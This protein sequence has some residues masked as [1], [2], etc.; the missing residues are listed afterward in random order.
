MRFDGH[1][2]HFG[3]GHFGHSKMRNNILKINQRKLRE[4]INTQLGLK[5]PKVGRPIR[6]T[7]PK[8][9]PDIR[10]GRANFVATK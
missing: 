7:K 8:G 5:P 2:G 1:F 6:K 4:F 9:R 3:H 10:R